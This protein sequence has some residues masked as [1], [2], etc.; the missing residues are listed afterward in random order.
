[1]DIK[2]YDTLNKWYDIAIMYNVLGA[3]KDNNQPTLFGCQNQSS[4]WPGTFIRMN[5]AT[6]TNTIGRYIGGGNKDNDLG[7][8]GYTH[9]LPVQTAPNKNVRDLN[10]G[11]KT[12]NFGTS[13][14]CAFSDANNTPFKF[15]EAKLM[16]FKLFLKPDADTQGTLTRDMIPCKTSKGTVGLFDKVNNKLY[17][18]PN[19]A[20]FEEGPEINS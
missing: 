6:T 19:G 12:H 20:V 9:E 14:F 5:N 8:N 1:L 17:V 18:S 11:G 2:L 13:L 7:L 10:N 4:P 15:I 3:G 16:Y